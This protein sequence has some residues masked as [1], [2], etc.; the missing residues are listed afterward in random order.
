[1][2]HSA[3]VLIAIEVAAWTTLY[4][5]VSFQD[6]GLRLSSVGATLKIA[7]AF[8]FGVPAVVLAQRGF[9]FRTLEIPFEEGLVSK[10][11]NPTD[12]Y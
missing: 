12:R 6:T 11:P 10:T 5:A 4:W 1:M 8:G 3:M 9:T 7:R 2:A